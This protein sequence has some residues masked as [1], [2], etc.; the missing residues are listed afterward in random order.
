MLSVKVFL[1]HGENVVSEDGA[2]GVSCGGPWVVEP[3][4]G[5]GEVIR[6]T[7]VGDQRDDWVRERVTQM[8]TMKLLHKRKYKMRVN[9]PISAKATTRKTKLTMTGKMR[10]IA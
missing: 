4:Y 7:G 10:P 1:D 6:S 9:W 3:R 8:V 5:E 2:S